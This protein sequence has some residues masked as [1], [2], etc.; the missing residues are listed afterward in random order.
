MRILT[1]F[2]VA[3]DYYPKERSIVKQY[4]D[5][6]FDIS[7]FDIEGICKLIKDEKIDGVLCG[8]S[9]SNTTNLYE[10]CKRAGLPCYLSENQIKL[11]NNKLYFKQE[12]SKY[13]Y[14]PLLFDY[15]QV[16]ESNENDI[17]P[18]IVKPIDCSAGIGVKICE[19][20]DELKQAYENATK[21]SKSNNRKR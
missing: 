5:E 15:Q 13:S 19:N 14:V 20:I 21:L 17:F 11:N 16:I 8:A 3:T 10:V 7:T 18:V 1:E 6:S 2:V 12:C 9:E 4:A